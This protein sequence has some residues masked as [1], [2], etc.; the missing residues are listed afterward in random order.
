M[1]SEGLHPNAASQRIEASSRHRGIALG[2]AAI[3][4]L[5]ACATI[6][7][8]RTPGP[9]ITPFLP[10]YLT[11]V[12][13]L[14][15]VTALLFL[16]HYLQRGRLSTLALSCAYLY[17]ACVVV[18]HAL[19][20][21]KVFS[22]EGLLGAGPQSAVWLWV[23]WHGGFPTLLLAYGLIRARE[24]RVG[25]PTTPPTARA[26]AMALAATLLLV[27]A[28]TATATLGHQLLPVIIRH[29]DYLLLVT[30]G[31]GPV[32]FLLNLAALATVWYVTRGRS[33]TQLWLLI[34][35][36]ASLLDVA[37]T[38]TAGARYSLGWYVARLNSLFSA[39]AV[40]GAFI[41]EFQQL[42]QRLAMANHRLSE[43]AD[44]DALTGLGNRRAFD[45]RLAE[46][47]VRAA[48][49]GQSLGL[50]LIDVDHFKRYNDSYGHPAGDACLQR[51]AE[52]VRANLHRPG[53]YAARYG[54]EELAVIVPGTDHAGTMHVAETIRQAIE[55]L[56][57]EHR[58]SPVG[59]VTAS[60]GVAVMAA[61]PAIKAS[62]LVAGA[63]TAL[64]AAKHG[65]RN[66]V[67]I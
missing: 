50:L 29:D 52:A 27:A 61:E 42:Q 21:P 36:L 63:D 2:V 33:I 65:G 19:T 37:V 12:V 4:I 34:A 60:L 38:L 64:Y 49:D 46:E 18:P 39:S 35:L 57:I 66:R 7:W 40:L 22:P 56:R 25:L 30:S 15:L 43:L 51:V 10:A 6:P 47:W 62:A 8:A 11:A 31:V 67:S 9:V 24:Q 13:V 41:F 53:D 45:R 17:T 32:V 23:F 59:R 16:L 1:S 55:A 54:G 48:R 14:D 58:E 5:V 44:T 20:F 28:L 26:I 3:I